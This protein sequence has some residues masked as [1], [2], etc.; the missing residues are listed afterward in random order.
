MAKTKDGF[1][2]ASEDV[3]NH[4]QK[5]GHKLKFF[6]TDSEQIMKW[7]PVKQPLENKGIQSEYSLPYVHYQNLVEICVNNYQGSVYHYPWPIFSECQFMELWFVL[8][9]RFP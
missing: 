5:Y 7:G 1:V 3:I 8:C 6:R 9:C 4:F 2:M